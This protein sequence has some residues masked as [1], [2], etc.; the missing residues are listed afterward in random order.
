[1]TEPTEQGGENL[2]TRLRR[3][4][5]VQWGIAYAA[6]TWT[7]LQVLEYFGETYA[8]PRAVRQIAGL[9]LPLGLLFVLVVAWYHGD[10]GEQKVSRTELAILATL[11]AFVGGTLW[12]YVSRID[13]SAWVVDTGVSETR[14]TVQ[15]DAASIAVLPFLDMSPGKD[16]EY[17][18]DGM[19]E[20]VLNLLTQLP[21]LRVIAR[22][23]SFSFKGKEVDIA[24]I[25]HK[26]N[27]AHVLEG[28][29]RKSG[30]TLRITAQLIRASD[31]THLWS[32]TYDRQL[33]DVFKVQDEI[34]RAVVAA[35]QVKLLPA[36]R[37]AAAPTVNAEAY[38]AYLKGLYHWYKLTREDLDA[39][40]RYFNLALSKEP[41]YARAYAG[42]ALLWMGRQQMGFVSPAE[43]APK[44]NAAALRAVELDDTLADAH[45]ALAV[46]STWANWDWPAAEREFR[47]A[48]QLN[49][50][51]ADAHAYYAHLLNLL[52]RPD[53]AMVEARRSLELDPFNGLFQALYGVDLIFARR[54]DEAIAHLDAALVTNPTDPVSLAVL[55]S[56][57]HH[58]REYRQA[59][60]ALSR[61]ASA[62][63]YSE[64]TTFLAQTTADADY[65]ATMRKAADTL[66]ARSRK[67]FVLPWDVASWYAYA[68]D[69][70]QCLKWLERAYEGRDP[71]LPYLWFPDFDFVRSDPRFRDLLKRI[72]LPD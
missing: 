39:A 34:A 49:P 25:A 53:E 71:N 18:A 27:V 50:G 12:W 3:R 43:A 58:K 5:V 28:S 17:F 23:S 7:L 35:L 51:F 20:E 55:I 11:V 26:L 31:S 47:R 57:H 13:E 22:T 60:E 38:D 40:E 4:K 33:T 36:Q 48:I 52:R 42:L 29:V 6:A 1:V 46:V 16:Q 30:G 9:A 61:Y 44:A 63:G 15:A 59:L 66:A 64:V 21:Q 32:Q 10:R 67:T 24:E 41:G 37:L 65:G 72:K 62:V 19:S 56:A 14:H 54:F 2:W 68:G 8:W 69:R 70:D 45:Y